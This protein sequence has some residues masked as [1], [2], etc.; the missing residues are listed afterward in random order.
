MLNMSHLEPAG[1]GEDDLQAVNFAD[2][3]YHRW[4]LDP[5]YRGAYPEDVAARLTLA[6][7]L[8]RSGDLATISAPMDFLGVNYYTRNIVRRSRPGSFLPNL[9]RP[10]GALTTMGWEVYP[11]GLYAVLQRLHY[12]Y[13][14][15]KLYITENGASYPDTPDPTGEVHD[16]ERVRYLGRH[17]LEV[18]RAL[19]AGVPLHGYFIWSLLDNFEWAHGYLP[20][21]GIVRVDFRAQQRTIKDSGY[22]AG[23]VAATNGGILDEDQAGFE[24]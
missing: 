19:A 3:L 1:D 12:E 20:R 23:R 10:Q 4:Y 7:G 17:L 22:F 21:F 11:E 8:V 6:E 15:A 16:Q 24:T 13:P 14:V 9:V 5:L 2:G 18:R